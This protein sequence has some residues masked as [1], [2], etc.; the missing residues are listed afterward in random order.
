MSTRLTTCGFLRRGKGDLKI[1]N[2][3]K[4]G[5]GFEWFF[6]VELESTC[7]LDSQMCDF[8]RNEGKDI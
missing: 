3:R 1:L 7:R 8:L 2:C 4:V 6:M 5:N